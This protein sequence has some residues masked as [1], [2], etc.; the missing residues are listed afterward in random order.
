MAETQ[1]VVAILIS[2]IASIISCIQLNIAMPSS[3]TEYM[4][5]RM[6]TVR[7]LSLLS[8]RT[9]KVKRL[10]KKHQRKKALLDLTW[11]NKRLVER[12]YW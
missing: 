9:A 2:L 3:H 12:F 5:K 1:K 8:T 11:A 10:G 4:K 7:L 6:N